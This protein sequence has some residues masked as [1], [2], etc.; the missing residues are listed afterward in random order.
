[1]FKSPQIIYLG[2]S[3][4]IMLKYCF[5]K[6]ESQ[7]HKFSWS[8]KLS[9]VKCQIILNVKVKSHIFTCTYTV[10]QAVRVFS[11]DLPL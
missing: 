3:K 6:S 11:I 8:L 5:G 10:L 9:D 4:Y 2:K 7:P 1:M